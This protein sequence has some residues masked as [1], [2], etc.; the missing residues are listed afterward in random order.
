MILSA[1]SLTSFQRCKR[2]YAL[3]RD[4][5]ALRWRPRALLEL[6]IRDGIFELS[7]GAPVDLVSSELCTR[8]LETAARPGLE[9]LSDPFT[10]ARDHCAIIQTVLEAVSRMVLLSLR[11]SDPVKIKDHQWN[12][13]S[14]VDESS[15]LHQWVLVDQWNEDVLHRTIHSWYVFG[16]CAATQSG[17]WLHAIEIGSQR[18][19]HQ[20]TPW[21][22][23][24]KHPAIANKIRF[25]KVDGSPLEGGWKPAWYQ[26]SDRNNAPT[27]VDLM[28]EDRLDLIH[29]VSIREPQLFHVKQFER[30][31]E[32]EVAA[33]QP[34]GNWQEAPMSRSACDLPYPC[35]FQ[36]V[37]YGAPGVGVESA[38]GFEKINLT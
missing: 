16:D 25:K 4:Y 11:H 6:L 5:R 37:C 15:V 10:L 19:G 17:L 22:R 28:E 14:W 2:R 12:P 13:S 1:A 27:W 23:A 18:G 29:H 38:G 20:H 34:L 21:C 31:I 24:Y 35:P 33:M 32:T 8:Y 9:C 26:D 7:S 30:E 36:P 3:E